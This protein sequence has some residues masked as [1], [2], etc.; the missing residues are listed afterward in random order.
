MCTVAL[1]VGNVGRELWEGWQQ[2]RKHVT[3]RLN[4]LHGGYPF[5]RAATSPSPN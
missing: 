5:I 4:R 1:F 2:R 3:P